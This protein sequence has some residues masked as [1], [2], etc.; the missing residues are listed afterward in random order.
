VTVTAADPVGITVDQL[1]ARLAITPR[2]VRRRVAAGTWPHHRISQR[3]VTFLPEDVRSIERLTAR[4]T[5]V[6]AST[7]EVRREATETRRL[8]RQRN[9]SRS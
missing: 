4:G 2:T 8:I 7:A 6:K 9:A 3:I 5:V 1:A